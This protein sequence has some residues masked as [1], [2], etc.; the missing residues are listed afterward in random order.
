MRWLTCLT[1]IIVVGSMASAADKTPRV[2]EC[3]P[4]ALILRQTGEH[5]TWDQLQQPGNPFEKLLDRIATNKTKQYLALLVRPG[6]RQFFRTARKTA[7]DRSIDVGYD[8]DE[9]VRSPKPNSCRFGFPSEDH[10]G[11]KKP[12]YFECRSNQVFFVDREGLETKVEHHLSD[13]GPGMHNG[14]NEFPELLRT[15]EVSNEYYKLL[16]NYLLGMVIALEPKLGVIG[17]G[18]DQLKLPDCRYRAVLS[19]FNEY[20]HFVIFLVRDDSFP[21][22]RKVRGIAEKNRFETYWELLAPNELIK[23]ATGGA[24]V[25]AN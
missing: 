20:T 3:S 1:A 6:S 5:V 23:F 4:N 15:M 24:L 11:D 14:P 18:P 17:D 10:A 25:P 12:V 22:F 8:V 7:M 2:V 19:K 21:V 16:P 9:P 13:M